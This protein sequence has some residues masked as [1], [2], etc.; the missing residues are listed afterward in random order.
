MLA[1]FKERKL[2]RERQKQRTDSTH[3]LSAVRD[4]NR[5]EI[6]GE[7]LHHALNVLAQ[8]DPMWLRS[9]I[10]PEWFDRYGQRFCDSRL[11]KQKQDR[12]QLAET[13]GRDGHHLLDRIYAESAPTYLRSIPA[14]EILCLV[15]IQHYYYD[16]K[17][18]SHWRGKKNFPPSSRMI[19]SPYDV[20]V[21]YSQKR[22]MEWHGYKVHLSE[23][24]EADSPNLITHVETT[25]A[26]DQDVT[27]VDAIHKGLAAKEL[28]PSQHLADGAYLSADL[29]VDSRE[30]YGVDLIGPVRPD[31]SWQAREENAFG[32]SDFSIDWESETVTCPKGHA[33]RYWKPATGPRGKATIQIH[34]D[35]ATCAACDARSRCTRS[36]HGARELTLHP[37][38]QH[39]AL[40]SARERQHTKEFF[41]IYRKRA[42][43]EGTVAQAAFTLGMRR[44]RYVGL[45][46]THL[47]H[48][49]TAA[50]INVQRFVDWSCERRRS[51][52]RVSHFAA[53]AA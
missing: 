48:V 27:K 17:G 36:R 18:E 33:S 29:L 49:V 53:M 9:Q 51:T 15:W 35:K 38:A 42:G 41:D 4:L 34:F 11:P 25:L 12:A 26:T 20:E 3:V 46:K 43:V 5:L 21:R 44:T 23:T 40:Q 30:E 1:V 8:V 16:E 37:Q 22:S 19:A 32:I 31:N 2:L 39:V 10:T 14:V 50:A 7:T 6:V 13:I 28:L 52:T 47:Q 24:C 45:A